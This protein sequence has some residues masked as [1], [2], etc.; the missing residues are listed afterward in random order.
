MPHAKA[1]KAAKVGRLSA[2]PSLTKCPIAR[3]P[4]PCFFPGAFAAF[5]LFA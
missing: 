5:A 4:K 3:A 1:A 2:E